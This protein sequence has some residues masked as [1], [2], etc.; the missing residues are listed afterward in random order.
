MSTRSPDS[1]ASSSSR[2]SPRPDSDLA[3]EYLWIAA[4]REPLGIT[5]GRLVAASYSDEVIRSGD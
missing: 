3:G 2:P 4:L 5:S 1:E